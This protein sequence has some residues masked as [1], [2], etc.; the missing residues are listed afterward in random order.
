MAD[1]QPTPEN[2]SEDA[3]D[4]QPEHKHIFSLSK[5][6]NKE[7]SV[8]SAE[9]SDIDTEILLTEKP[10][11]GD[12]DKRVSA[13]SKVNFSKL[14]E[15]EKD[16]RLKN[17]AKLVKRLRRKVRNLEQKFKTNANKI[18]GN[19]LHHSLGVK[20]YQMATSN[21][22]AALE[23]TL[24]NISKALKNVR[25]YDGFEYE[26]QKNVVENLINLLAEEK[27]SLDSINSGKICSQ[28]RLFLNKE[29]IKYISKKGQKIV[30]SF[31]REGY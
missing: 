12:I 3:D 8:S 19:Y 18:F 10:E 30:F 21:Q 1:W 17:L 4:D 23:L 11:D 22:N 20:K 9:S 14:K 7:E 25:A 15:Q 29:K 24:E 26:D 31:P 6:E 2:F 13:Y 28:I 16:E 5:G 27:I